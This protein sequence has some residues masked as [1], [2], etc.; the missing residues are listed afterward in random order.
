MLCFPGDVQH[1]VKLRAM[2][3]P[4]RLILRNRRYEPLD[5]FEALFE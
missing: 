3:G 4:T 5:G 2:P 1:P